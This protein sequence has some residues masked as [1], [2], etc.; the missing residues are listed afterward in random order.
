M[1]TFAVFFLILS[2]LVLI[3]EFGHFITAKKFGIKV[4]E[5]GFG[6]PPRVLGKQRGETL[7]S[8][9]ALPFGGF[10]KLLGEDSEDEKA[11]L[12]PRSFGA[13]SPWKRAIILVAGVTMNVLLG[14]AI[15]Y[16]FFSIT[17]FKSLTIPLLYD[18]DFKFGQE[19]TVNTVISGFSEESL[20]DDAGIKSGEA[21]LE[22]NNVPVYTLND[23]KTQVKD[24]PNQKVKLLVMDVISLE[25]TLRTVEVTTINGD[26]GEG[27]LGVGLSKAVTLSYQG[28][29]RPLAGF[30]HDYNIMSYSAHTF[31]NI[32]KDSV[33]EK[34][35]TLV[36]SSVSG[37]IGIFGVVGSILDY[38][39]KEAF[40]G[41][42]DLTAILSLS[43]AFLNVMPFPALDGGRLVFV[44]F[45]ALT[46]KKPSQKIETTIHKWGMLF[47]LLLIALVTI[48]DLT[49]IFG[50]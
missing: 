30:Y 36:S 20:A 5:F 47:L 38:G 16:V 40:L 45:E 22:I 35:A 27:L 49:S 50:S 15:Y 42:M 33:R 48:K 46:K 34:D 26:K 44:L 32:I 43:L 1:I 19:K 37:P 11:N 3:H 6:L 7:Y 31:G 23:V 8:I 18:Y 39:G 4:E 21:I 41:I 2:L 9:N 24:K 14:V 12:D 17:N 13:K 28:N 29:Q 25:N 10:V